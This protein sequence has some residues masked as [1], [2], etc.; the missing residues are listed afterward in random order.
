MCIVYVYKF[1]MKPQHIESKVTSWREDKVDLAIKA[2]TNVKDY[3][4]HS[5]IAE[6]NLGT[7]WVSGQQLSFL[8]CNSPEKRKKMLLNWDNQK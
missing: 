6:L 3:R 5:L 7:E 8:G 1:F 4:P 2:G